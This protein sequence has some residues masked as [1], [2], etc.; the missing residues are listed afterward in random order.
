MTIEEL[1]KIFCDHPHVQT[2]SRKVISGDLFFAL[3]GP[4]FNG[5]VF[6]HQA[7]ETGAAYAICDEEPAE[8]N[9]KIIIVADV[10]KCLQD[11]AKMHRETFE[12]P[13]IAITGSN[14]K[15]STKELLHSVL[16]KK[17]IC[18]TTE[19]NLNNHIGVPLTLLKI[20]TDAEI[21]IVEMGANH[22]GE[23]KDYCAYTQPT[24]GLITNI[25][26]AHLEGF[27]GEEGVRKGKGEL[28]KYLEAHDGS[29]FVNTADENILNISK[30]LQRILTYGSSGDISGSGY[31]SE[32]YLIVEELKG[33]T[34]QSIN[35]NLVGTY[36]LSNVLAAVCVGKHFGVED[37]DIKNAIE[38]Y[39]PINSRSQLL[40]KDNNDIVL[41]A[42]NAN[43]SSMAAAI[44]NFAETAGK[45]KILY[46]GEMKELGS[47]SE[48]EHQ[49]LVEHLTQFAWKEVVL[50]GEG[51]N[52]FHGAYRWFSDSSSAA[53]WFALQQYNNCNILIKGSR[54]MK[55]ENVLS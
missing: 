41:D 37:A 6:A 11:L 54:S 2:D 52:K 53:E 16:S 42:Y 25:G 24:H 23:I 14:G 50:V 13:I 33:T 4:S 22:Q 7:L 21:A 47:D 8:I 5:N 20:K 46:L 35:T 45:N 1:Y 34:I 12:I 36:N 44:Q 9:D 15:T 27:G 43:P 17:Y 18:Y 55:M 31:L 40:R 48:K 30:K 32:K 26:K 51:F 10:L 49:M 38:N 29:A 28:F 3:K 19:G 39:K